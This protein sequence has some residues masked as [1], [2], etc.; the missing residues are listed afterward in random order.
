MTY[1]GGTLEFRF[2][3]RNGQEWTVRSDNILPSRWYHLL[4]TWD[5][6]EGLALYVN[7]DQVDRDRNPRIRAPSGA[8]AAGA[9]RG[10]ASGAAA[11]EYNEFI[12]GKPNDGQPATDRHPLLVDEF[13]FWSTYMNDTDVRNVGKF[14][15][16]RGLLSTRLCFLIWRKS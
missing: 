13:N 7:G 14:R 16:W 15:G 12:I 8:A 3:R 2:R 10:K 1:D 9:A 6:A 5:A 4:A 11:S